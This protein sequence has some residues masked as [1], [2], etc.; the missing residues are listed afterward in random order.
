MVIGNYTIFESVRKSR[1]GGGGLALG[2]DKLLHPVWLRDG[3]ENVEALSVEISVR[4][5]KIRCC[6]A[7]GPQENDLVDRKNAFWSYLDEEVT[8]AKRSGSGLV[9]HFDGNLWAGPNIIPGDPT[10]QNRN[11]KM[12]EEFLSR[13]PQLTAVNAL[14]LCQGLITRRSLR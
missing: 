2:C 12:L 7:Y 8:Q 6:V 14:P 3:E 10:Q 5:M 11:G 1:D 4:E 13:N 9:L